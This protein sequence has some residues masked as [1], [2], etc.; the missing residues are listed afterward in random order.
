MGKSTLSAYKIFSAVHGED[1]TVLDV[2]AFEMFFFISIFVAFFLLF[3][4]IYSMTTFLI[5]KL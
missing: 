2:M 3:P 4:N 1:S 5:N